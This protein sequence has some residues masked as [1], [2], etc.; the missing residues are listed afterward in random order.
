MSTP[1]DEL[2][3]ELVKIEEK[4]LRKLEEQVQS[5]MKLRENLYSFLDLWKNA[6]G[7]E[8]ITKI[9]YRRKK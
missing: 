7:Q 1:Q 3:L 6:I 8:N 2:E 4:G 9:L 5:A